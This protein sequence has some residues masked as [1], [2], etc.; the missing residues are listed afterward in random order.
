MRGKS[1]AEPNLR[2]CAWKFSRTGGDGAFEVLQTRMLTANCC[3]HVTS[4]AP[5]HLAEST[6][7]LIRLAIYLSGL[8][9]YSTGLRFMSRAILSSF[10]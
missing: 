10:S 1:G 2:Y 8:H 6:S 7:F 3:K 9:R 4:K 5:I